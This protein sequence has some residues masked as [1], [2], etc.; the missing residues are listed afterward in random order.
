MA[1]FYAIK[2]K[3]KLA[4]IKKKVKAKQAAKCMAKA[5]NL[6]KEPF[7]FLTLRLIK[8]QPYYNNLNINIIGKNKLQFNNASKYAANMLDNRLI[9]A[10]ISL[11]M[12]L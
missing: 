6:N 12:P 7:K 4:F 8:K 5:Y 1:C 10:N 9:G 3:G 11:L 2:C